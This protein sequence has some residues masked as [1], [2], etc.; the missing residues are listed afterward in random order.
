MTCKCIKISEIILHGLR[1]F[2][3][4]HLFRVSNIISWYVSIYVDIDI[5]RY[6]KI[7]NAQQMC[8]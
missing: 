1:K 4:L 7:N 8:V 2:C 3:I 6:N 5:C